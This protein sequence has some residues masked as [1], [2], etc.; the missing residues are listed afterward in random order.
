MSNN[1][2]IIDRLRNILNEYVGLRADFFAMITYDE[3]RRM[4]LPIILPCGSPNEAQTENIAKY[5][6][7]GSF[8]FGRINGEA[9]IKYGGLVHDKN[10]WLE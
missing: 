7:A 2:L 8:T 6:A 9:H 1:S 5:L 10:C 4:E 3:P